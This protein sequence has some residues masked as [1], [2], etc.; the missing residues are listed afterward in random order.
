MLDTIPPSIAT[1][2]RYSK[3]NA[4]FHQFADAV[5]FTEN[6]GLFQSHRLIVESR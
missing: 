3:G 2:D 4:S 6:I 5:G 1:S